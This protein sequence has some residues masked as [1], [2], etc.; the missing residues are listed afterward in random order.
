MPTYLLYAYF[1]DIQIIDLLNIAGINNYADV[2]E[3]GAVLKV[4]LMWD[5]ELGSKGKLYII[6]DIRVRDFFES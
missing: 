6:A 1:S 3:Y 5:C 4:T 2:T